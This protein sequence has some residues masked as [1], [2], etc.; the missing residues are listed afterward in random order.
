MS[1]HESSNSQDLFFLKD[2]RIDDWLV[3]GFKKR[4]CSVSFIGRND[5]ANVISM[6]RL[7]RIKTLHQQYLKIAWKGIMKSERKD[8][9]ICYLDV[10]GMYVFLL[11]KILLRRREILVINIM[12]N[13][14]QDFLTGIKR[15]LYKAML[16]SKH[17]YPTVISSELPLLYKRI[18]NLPS[19]VFYVM[20]DCYGDLDKA[21]PDR[22]DE[23]EYVF[24]GGTASRDW[25]LMKEVTYKL[26]D[27]KFVIVGPNKNTLGENIPPNV[28]YYYNLP[29]VEFRYL[30]NR[31]S[32][33]AL[34]LNTEAPAGLI[35][36]FTAG[37]MSKAVV[38]TD[39]VTTREYI[40]N[41]VN[42]RMVKMKDVD[43]F[44]MQIQDLINDKGKRISYG[45]A[46]RL[47]VEEYG[48]PDSFIDA[49]IDIT[50]QI[51]AD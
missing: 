38:T 14:K 43:D 11:S 16:R 26:P 17:V 51:R 12:F 34:P 27:T 8:I 7:I 33:L 9:I 30:L 28:T 19:K 39:N 31:S 23:D 35:V 42:G 10:V 46:L 4:G 45:K 13:D 1:G 41:G 50:N 15:V 18:F 5:R 3:S 24:C 37:L 32:L 22:T 49:I 25:N 6:S 47:K 48:S 2:S 40:V 21:I 44:A 20:H 36:L 29:S